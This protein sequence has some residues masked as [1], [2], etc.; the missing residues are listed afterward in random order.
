MLD[1]GCGPGYVLNFMPQIDYT[2]FDTEPRYIKYA[3]EHYPGRGK[4]YCE[5]FAR[6][7]VTKFEPFDAVIL[8]GIIH[9]LDDS[10]ASGLLKLLAQCLTPQGRIV[11]L[12]PCLT[13]GRSLVAR[14]VAA[15]DRGRFVREEQAY[16]Q[17]A[18][19]RFADIEST[20]VSNTCRIPSTEL[21]MRIRCPSQPDKR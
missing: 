14:W 19:E 12:D 11:T 1:I 3:S 10:E 5:R 16:R 2:G 7:H 9:H 15:S 18:S 21:I 4:F 6:H 20:I 13:T 8:F 17:L